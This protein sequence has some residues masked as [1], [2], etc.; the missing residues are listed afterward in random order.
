MLSAAI[1]RNAAAAATAAKQPPSHFKIT[2]M[3]S[4]IGLAPDVRKTVTALGFKKRMQSVYRS[5]NAKNVGRIVK[6]K[7]L[8][9]VET[10]D[11]EAVE[12]E[13]R[14]KIRSEN[15]GYTVVRRA[16]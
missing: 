1:L 8:V 3:R 7:E 16:L 11:R 10:M 6:I 15:K 9:K 5:I 4:S 13:L 2:L 14:P 12:E